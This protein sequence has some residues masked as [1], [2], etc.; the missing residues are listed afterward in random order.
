VIVCKDLPDAVST[1]DEME[2][3]LTDGNREKRTEQDIFLHQAAAV[4]AADSESGRPDCIF[5]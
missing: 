3:S 1:G 2:L 4:Y 5:E